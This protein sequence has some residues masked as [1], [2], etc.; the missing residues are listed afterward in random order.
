MIL[1]AMPVF[2]YCTLCRWRKALYIGSIWQLKLDDKIM[3]GEQVEIKIGNA[4]P[5]KVYPAGHHGT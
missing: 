3:S 2:A 5:L 4:L 1:T